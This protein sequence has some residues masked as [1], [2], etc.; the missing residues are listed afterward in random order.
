MRVWLNRLAVW[1]SKGTET[2]NA[3]EGWTD[4]LSI[5]LPPGR[6]V[7]ELVEQVIQAALREAP[8]DAIAREV[9]TRGARSATRY[10]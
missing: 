4:D 2:S 10:A 1:R 5:R 6:T 8:D 3:P 7:D 9:M